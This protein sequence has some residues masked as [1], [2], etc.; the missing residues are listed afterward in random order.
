[1]ATVGSFGIDLGLNTARFEEGLKRAG[2]GADNGADLVF[3]ETG[4]LQRHVAEPA[5]G[6]ETRV[7]KADDGDVGGMPLQVYPLSAEAHRKRHA[8]DR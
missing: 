8:A 4:E 5:V 1:M 2:T 7:A 3:E 6:G